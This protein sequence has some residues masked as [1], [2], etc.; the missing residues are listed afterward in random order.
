MKIK[1][2]ELSVLRTELGQE[3]IHGRFK[4]MV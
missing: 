2:V 1:D 4:I 3:V